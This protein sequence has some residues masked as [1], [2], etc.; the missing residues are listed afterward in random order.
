MK[1]EMSPFGKALFELFGEITKTQAEMIK[2]TQQLS[3]PTVT[4]R[5]N[6]A[7]IN[8]E[9]IAEN[10]R[11][12]HGLHEESEIGTENWEMHETAKRDN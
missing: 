4:L 5:E 3:K 1:N 7:K 2:V 11:K 12:A 8:P 9:V 6:L 10:V